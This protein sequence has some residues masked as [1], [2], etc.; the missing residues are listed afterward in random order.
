MS[1]RFSL[2]GPGRA[3]TS[4]ATALVTLGWQHASTF[5]RHDDP[6][7]AADGVELLVVATPDSAI[8]R[9]TAKVAPGDAVVIHLSGATP[10]DAIGG[11]RHGALH[12]LVSLADPVEG[13]VA[14][15]SAWFAVAGD[16]IVQHLAESL[17]GKWFELRDED[18]VLYHAAAVIG[19]NHLV[20]LLGQVERLGGEIGVPLDAFLS[21]ARSSVDNVERLGPA[22][23]LT[24]PVARGDEETIEM[25]RA[26]LAAR[27]ADELDGYDAVLGLARRLVDPGAMAD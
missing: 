26:E 25:H 21:L 8:E 1:R 11:H 5:G 2:I 7:H 19:S 17:S 15:R 10:L 12:P 9:V 14:L 22:G 20:A 16:P 4:L 27:M 3:G 18:R 6:T 13:A 23:A 24:G